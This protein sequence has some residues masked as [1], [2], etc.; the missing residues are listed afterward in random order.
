MAVF[1]SRFGF[2]EEIPPTPPPRRQQFSITLAMSRE[3]HF[4]KPREREEKYVYKI[5]GGRQPL[6]LG[7]PKEAP[8]VAGGEGPGQGGGGGPEA[9]SG[10][11]ARRRKQHPPGSWVHPLFR[12]RAEARG[13]VL[14]GEGDLWLV[15]SRQR[16]TELPEARSRSPGRFYDAPWPARDVPS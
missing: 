2:L 4:W 12:A 3:D 16:P 7:S 5:E 15:H 1:P 13:V 8:H 11:R 14:P 9:R 10:R 6:K